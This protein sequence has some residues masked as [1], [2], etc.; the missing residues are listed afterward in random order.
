MASPQASNPVILTPLDGSEMSDFALPYLAEVAS[1]LGAAPVVARIVERTHWTSAASGYLVA[2]QVY[3]D[4]LEAQETD[5]KSQ[6]TRAVAWLGQRGLAGR[7]VVDFAISP[8]NLV[9]MC[10]R[11]H[12][13][14]VVMATH[15][16]SG[17]ARAT[18]G[19]VADHVVRHGP[20]PTLLLRARG[21]LAERPALADALVPLDGSAMSEVALPTLA[22]LAGK[23]VK[24]VTLLRVVE[25]DARSGAAA[26]ARQSL[27]ATRE[28]IEREMEALRGRVE[29]LVVWGAPSQQIL[30]EAAH[31]DLI[32]MATH[33]ET[34][35][36]R[37]AFGSVADETLRDARTPLLLTRPQTRA[38]Q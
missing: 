35:A 25:P 3:A 14:M 24:R 16:R 33:G 36:T 26:G 21:R 4:L 15:G 2:P 10:G 19:S 34:G 8:A 12:A 20:C 7:A 32:I 38:T 13:T 22:S 6:T 27:E 31:H 18:L 37:W 23:L 28:R 5:A 11:E 17:M 1:A 29:M 30:E 9:E